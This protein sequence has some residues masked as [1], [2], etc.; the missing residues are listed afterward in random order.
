MRTK[1]IGGAGGALVLLGA[2]AFW[3]V[4]GG[5]SPL[6]RLL[7]AS[8][9]GRSPEMAAGVGYARAQGGSGIGAMAGLAIGEA[10]NAERSV[11]GES[12]V[13]GLDLEALAALAREREEREAAER[14]AAADAESEQGGEGDARRGGRRNRADANGDGFIDRD[15]WAQEW[16][17]READREQRRAEMVERFDRD[18]DGEVSREERQEAWREERAARDLERYDV[19][20][21]GVLSEAEAAKRDQDRSQAELRRKAE[22]EVR[23]LQ[24]YDADGDGQITDTERET[25]DAERRSRWEQV[26]AD[27]DAARSYYDADGDGRLDMD[28][29]YEA[30]LQRYETQQRERVLGI[31]DTDGDGLISDGEVAGFAG[32]MA[33]GDESADLDGDGVIG[34][35]DIEVLRSATEGP[36]DPDAPAASPWGRRGPR[37]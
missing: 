17:R 32:L 16:E 21:D 34:P 14:A 8:W 19:D 22:R 18:G 1:L 36:I 13:N 7:P 6:A 9:V 4:E 35:G 27:R 5:G 10:G 26:R 25:V 23:D 31:A 3:P 28:E 37:R 24:R 11:V 33:S 29:S 15:E 12:A 30:Y 2:A 20:G